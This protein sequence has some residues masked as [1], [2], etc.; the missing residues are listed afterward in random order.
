M[1]DMG[2]FIGSRKATNRQGEIEESRVKMIEKAQHFAVNVKI[3]AWAP[4]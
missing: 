4:E 1:E 2:V 3:S